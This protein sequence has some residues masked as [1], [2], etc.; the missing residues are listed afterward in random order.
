[1]KTKRSLLCCRP[2]AGSQGLYVLSWQI[3]PALTSL[4]CAGFLAPAHAALLISSQ[5]TSNVVCSGRSNTCIATA[6]N[7]VLNAGHLARLL[8][9]HD[10]TVSSGKTAGDVVL[11]APFSWT[12]GYALTLD[13]HRSIRLDDVLGVAGSGALALRTN[14]GGRNGALSFHRAGRVAFN[15]LANA[16]VIDRTK[17]RLVG[18]I[19]GMASAIKANPSGNFALADNYDASADGTYSSA[20]IR[21]PVKGMV[22][23]L[24]NAISNLTID[25]QTAGDAVGLIAQVS[26]G[27]IVSDMTLENANISA[28]SKTIVGA[29]AVINAGGT[30]KGSSSSVTVIAGDKTAIGGLVGFNRA[31]FYKKKFLEPAVSDCHTVFSIVAGAGSYVGGLIGAN[32]GVALTSSADGNIAAGKN[33]VAGGL[34]AYTTNEIE[35]SYATGSISGG[36]GA[37]IGGLAGLSFG[38]IIQSYAYVGLDAAGTRKD[39]G[40]VGGLSAY[41]A[42]KIVESYSAGIV[43]GTNATLGG[44]LGMDESNGDNFTSYWDFDTS[45]ITDPGQGAGNIANDPGITGLSNAQF[46]IALPEYFDPA[47][48]AENPTLNGGLPYLIDNPPQ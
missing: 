33:S 36:V 14:D 23:G 38:S 11:A 22:E 4:L 21:T 19:A 17:Y 8:A 27:G 41:A 46:Q 26:A 7:A 16:F 43:S 44:F 37:W 32:Q 42:G 18:S 35:R 29:L 1:M 6:R 25:D 39:G 9:R 5:T 45:G 34:V 13:A 28:G 2:A 24:G 48:W 3:V 12:S 15:G 31:G 10:V 40:I 47:V 30:V 20:P